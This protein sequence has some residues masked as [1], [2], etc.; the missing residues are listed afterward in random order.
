MELL[1]AIAIC[2][3]GILLF[4]M[5]ASAL[6]LPCEEE[7]LVTLWRLEGDASSLEK[8]AR[9][10]T[11]LHKAGCL[12]TVVMLDAGLTADARKRAKLLARDELWLHLIAEKDLCAYFDFTRTDHGTGI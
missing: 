8:T 6:L 4:W 7:E 5:L 12:H 3:C 11:I 2:G 9:G 10:L 1:A